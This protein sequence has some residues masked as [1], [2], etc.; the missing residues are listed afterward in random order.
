MWHKL[1][2][3]CGL[4]PTYRIIP[5]CLANFLVACLQ[6]PPIVVGPL[7]ASRV[8]LDRNFH[9]HLFLRLS[10][11]DPTYGSQPHQQRLMQAHQQQLQTMEAA[12]THTQQQQSQQQRQQQ[13]QQQQQLSQQLSQ[14]H[15]LASPHAASNSGHGSTAR[16]TLMGIKL[17]AV[18]GG[19]KRVTAGTEDV[20]SSGSPLPQPPTPVLQTESHLQNQ[21]LLLP[22]QQAQQQRLALRSFA[23]DPAVATA[24]AAAATAS[25]A[26]PA[27]MPLPP[28]PPTPSTKSVAPLLFDGAAAPPGPARDSALML[29]SAAAVSEAGL[30]PTDSGE[31][32]LTMPSIM[33]P[34]CP[35]RQ[36]VVVDTT[37]TGALP[38]GA[39][40]ADG[41]GLGAGAAIGMAVASGLASAPTG[42]AAGVPGSGTRPFGLSGIVTGVSGRLM[43]P[44]RVAPSAGVG[45]DNSGTHT[46][47]HTPT[48]AGAPAAAGTPPPPMHVPPPPYIPS[49]AQDV[50]EFGQ[51]LCRIFVVHTDTPDTSR[52]Q[53]L[54]ISAAFDRDSLSDGAVG[55][56]DAGGGGAGGGGGT[57]HGA[58]GA[59]PLAFGS[60]SGGR[61]RSGA[62]PPSGAAPTVPARSPFNPS[63]RAPAGSGRASPAALPTEPPLTQQQL[64]QLL[65][66]ASTSIGDNNNLSRASSGLSNMGLQLATGSRGGGI[67]TATAASPF[68]LQQQA[69]QAISVDSP[70]S[71]DEVL[72]ALYEV[73]P[74]LS[75]LAGSCMHPDPAQRPS[76]PQVLF[77]FENI[78][79]PALLSGTLGIS[80]LEGMGPD[81]AGGWG[82]DDGGCSSPLTQ[83]HHAHTTH[84]AHASSAT[85]SMA[86]ALGLSMAEGGA[87]GGGG[88][89]DVCGDSS[90]SGRT[91][92]D[93]G[94]GGTLPRSSGPR[95]DSSNHHGAAAGAGAGMGAGA[96]A[97]AAGGVGPTRPNPFFSNISH[98]FQSV[99]KG[100]S[101]PPPSSC[102]GAAAPM[103]ASAPTAPGVQATGGLMAA[104]RQHL[105]H[106][107]SQRAASNPAGPA[108][109]GNMALPPVPQLTAPG[110]A[111]GF[112]ATAGPP[113]A[114]AAVAA[115]SMLVGRCSG[116]FT[117]QP[118][119][120]VPARTGLLGAG[121]D[122]GVGRMG[123]VAAADDFLFD[124]FPPKVR[125][126][127]GRQALMGVLCLLRACKCTVAGRA[128][129]GGGRCRRTAVAHRLRPCSV[130]DAMC[131]VMCVA[132]CCLLPQV[133]RSLL[134]GETPQPE[135]FEVVSIYFS[136]GEN[137]GQA[138][139]PCSYT[140]SLPSVEPAPCRTVACQAARPHTPAAPLVPCILP[141]S[142]TLHF[143]GLSLPPCA[144]H[145]YNAPTSLPPTHSL[146]CLPACP[147]LQLWA[148]PT[149]V[150]SCSLTR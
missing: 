38:L 108:S 114:V 144:T 57:G 126:T 137:I 70:E 51:L 107:G 16:R 111:G 12:Q 43:L 14:A 55:R 90:V 29:T 7:H 63:G 27:A 122:L 65:P 19:F 125:S 84:H 100:H 5:S 89:G 69:T 24:A 134:M 42:C 30:Q 78:V 66:V 146:A 95:R 17:A 41:A 82:D 40:V 80:G 72:E 64:Q 105:R 54:R 10:S 76:F 60:G 11:L 71:I 62:P 113:P 94:V 129:V 131:A 21:L 75:E 3:V 46:V 91:T 103:N 8:L 34:S 18:T 130:L 133:A 142:L 109:H 132:C 48:L 22:Q 68:P 93:G 124:F 92:N 39:G 59:L 127:G 26:A 147:L 45:G 33:A 52:D 149:C 35:Q 77:T 115:A 136:D 106:R 37:D 118:Q 67:T 61:N 88:G 83:P 102:S 128:L 148:T 47:A 119:R 98:A 141:L 85:R 74:E 4:K 112:G 120:H 44:S 121:P 25:L 31:V 135:R 50:Y 49:C 143:R 150:P 86:Q 36:L 97:A 79:R 6:E 87:A 73:C 96:G 20:T 139:F 81:S 110:E 145:S 53:L 56:G 9:P 23:F 104:A 123:H 140:S 116:S 32:H 99:A 138:C 28:T 15:S 2:L 117:Q 101:K 13:Y 58:G 1:L